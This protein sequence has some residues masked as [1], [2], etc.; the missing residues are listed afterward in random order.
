[1]RSIVYTVLVCLQMS[2]C[3]CLLWAFK[4]GS[5]EPENAAEWLLAM[6]AIQKD[7]GKKAA[8]F[9]FRD[10]MK[11]KVIGRL[12]LRQAAL[13]LLRRTEIGR[14]S[15]WRTL[16]FG[17]T[18]KGKPYLTLDLGSEAFGLNISHHGDY[19]VLAATCSPLCGVDVMKNEIPSERV[20]RYRKVC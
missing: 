9:L 1:M 17:R 6:E 12:M 4:V 3:K 15:T 11:T 8:R 5:W 10:D 18:E 14:D 16:D 2:R 7:E 20:L 19:V 13:R